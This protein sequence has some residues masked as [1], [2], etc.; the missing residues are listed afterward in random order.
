MQVVHPHLAQIVRVVAVIDLLAQVIEHQLV[1]PVVDALAR[2]VQVYAPARDLLRPT[3]PHQHQV[4]ILGAGHPLG[5]QILI[6][7]LLAGLAVV[8]GHR[9]AVGLLV[10]V[11]VQQLLHR[12][13][14]GRV[15]RDP[16][17]LQDE[18]QALR[19]LQHIAAG[20]GIE[21]TGEVVF[22]IPEAP[23]DDLRFCVPHNGVCHVN[24]QPLEYRGRFKPLLAVLRLLFAVAQAAHIVGQEL[25]A[26][27]YIDVLRD[28]VF[29]DATP[30]R[31]QSGLAAGG[32]GD[33]APGK[34]ARPGVEEGC[35]VQPVALAVLSLGDNIEGVVVGD[36]PL[37]AP[38]IVVDTADIW[39]AAVTEGF[40]TLPAQYLQRLRDVGLR[41]A[42]EGRVA[43][44]IPNQL[45]E[46]RLHL[47]LGVLI[48]LFQGVLP[49]IQIE[50]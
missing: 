17:I 2:D 34:D 16:T 13:H 23:L 45:R 1:V 25:A 41:P 22:H 21:Q 9:T 44:H 10:K 27:V 40:L 30:Q 42:V 46:A 37:V 50:V 32:V 20:E 35:Q 26:I 8:F 12:F 38:H 28:A 31:D 14:Q 49:L 6:V 29:Q 18:L 11:P 19:L 3:A 47:Q 24:A 36:P 48:A 39:S 7:D 15:Q 43:R 33:I 5:V 4:Q